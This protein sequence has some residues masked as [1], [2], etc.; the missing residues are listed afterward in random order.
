MQMEVEDKSLEKLRDLR[1]YYARQLRYIDEM[2]VR[3]KDFNFSQF[4]TVKKIDDLPDWTKKTKAK[5]F[6]L[7]V[8]RNVISTRLRNSLINNT[9]DDE[10]LCEVILWDLKKFLKLPEIGRKSAREALEL[11]D[12]LSKQPNHIF[13]K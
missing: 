13:T 7:S 8:P 12:Y 2:I 1:Q 9:F 3:H 6:F 5:D 11:M 10:M 4:D